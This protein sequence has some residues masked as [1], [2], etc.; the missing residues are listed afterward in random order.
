VII[1]EPSH[2]RTAEAGQC[3]EPYSFRGS[4][5]VLND[6]VPLETYAATITEMKTR[7]L[8]RV[9]SCPIP[10]HEDSSPSFT[11]YPESGRWYCFGCSRGGDLLDLFMAV[12]DWSEDAYGPALAAMAQKFGVELPQRPQKWHRWQDEKARIREAA[13]QR[14]AAIYQRRLT[15]VYAPLVLVG[16]ETPEEELE[17]LE[18]LASAL[19][20]MSLSLAGRRVSGEE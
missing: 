5:E 1:S 15:R 14:V 8:R 7:G 10:G 6:A 4:L 20:P 2:P 12:E 3:R 11:I 19:W 9:G 16:G 18:G 17:A 13:T